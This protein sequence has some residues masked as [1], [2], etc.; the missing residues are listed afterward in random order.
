LSS[1][2]TVSTLPDDFKLKN[3]CADIQ[4]SPSGES[5]YVSNRGYNS[6]ACY[7]I[8]SQTGRLTPVGQ[9]PADAETR[10]FNLGP[11]GNFLYAAGLATGRLISYRV[12]EATG[13][14]KPFEIYNV[15]KEPWWVLIPK[16]P[17]MP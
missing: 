14:L 2:Q 3:R 13:E 7:A 6:I 16:P 8:E 4:I 11:E 10:S 1:L 9:V 12:N 15:G 5:L 17:L